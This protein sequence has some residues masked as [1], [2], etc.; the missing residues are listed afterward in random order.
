MYW[1]Y[2]EGR[3]LSWVLQIKRGIRFSPCLL[4]LPNLVGRIQISYTEE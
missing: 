1:A 4:H 2:T 3:A